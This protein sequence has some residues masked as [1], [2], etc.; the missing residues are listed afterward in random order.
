MG[1]IRL[2]GLKSNL[3]KTIEGLEEYGGVEIKQLSSHEIKNA[4]NL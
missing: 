1:K 4:K 2:I 3:K